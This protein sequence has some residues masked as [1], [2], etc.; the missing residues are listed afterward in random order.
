MFQ[1]TF[2]L[3][4]FLKFYP[5]VGRNSWKP[6]EGQNPLSALFGNLLPLLNNFCLDVG[7]KWLWMHILSN[8]WEGVQPRLAVILVRVTSVKFQLW[9]CSS[10][11]IRIWTALEV[12]FRTVWTWRN[13]NWVIW[14]FKNLKSDHFWRFYDLKTKLEQ[15]IRIR[16]VSHFL[17]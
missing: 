11:D 9:D 5:T 12:T 6:A 8:L 3:N 13:V 15:E 1:G 14:V 16:Q 2:W 4:F 7:Q 10:L 17:R